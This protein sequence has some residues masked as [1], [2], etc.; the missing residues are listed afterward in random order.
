MRLLV[1]RRQGSGREQSPRGGL[2]HIHLL[3]RVENIVDHALHCP[4]LHS[5]CRKVFRSP[6]K[7]DKKVS[8]REPSDLCD[9]LHV[10]GPHGMVNDYWTL[11]NTYVP[12]P[13]ARDTHV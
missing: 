7:H 9:S 13:A 1:V 10:L 3:F 5:F 6:L 8:S 2:Y 11:E 4:S 12:Q